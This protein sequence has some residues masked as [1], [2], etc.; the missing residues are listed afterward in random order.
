MRERFHSNELVQQIVMTDP[1]VAARIQQLG[2]AYARVVADPVLRQAQGSRLLAQQ[3]TRE[4]NILAFNDVF[5]VVGVLASVAL[6]WLGGR[7]I[8]L[9][10]N[11]INPFA[12]DLAALQRMMANR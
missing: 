7:W 5:M 10:I 4:A 8:Y 3:I 2:G 11:K 1:Q 9:R 12:E 6:L